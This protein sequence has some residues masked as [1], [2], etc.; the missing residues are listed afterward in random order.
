MH[1]ATQLYVYAL[2]VI[3][4]WPITNID[5]IANFFFFIAYFEAPAATPSP[6]STTLT[7]IHVM[8]LG[9]LAV[10]TEIWRWRFCSV[11]FAFAYTPR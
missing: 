6:I 2:C 10:S 1:H 4:V 11:G 9:F 7:V 5:S 8:F 3:L